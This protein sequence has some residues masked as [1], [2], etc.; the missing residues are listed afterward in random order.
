MFCFRVLKPPGGG[1]SDIF[2]ADEQ[3]EPRKG[4]AQVQQ[5]SSLFM[6]H[7][8]ATTPVKTKS[9]NDTESHVK[10]FDQKSSRFSSAAKNKDKFKSNI[11]FGTDDSPFPSAKKSVETV[12]VGVAGL[13]DIGID[14]QNG[15]NRGKFKLQSYLKPSHCL[16]V[17]C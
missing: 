11:V 3:T 10:L 9:G 14:S 6:S 8:E 12:D 17:Q 4:R 15:S 7:D 16:S 2:G 5:Q 13:P 1:S